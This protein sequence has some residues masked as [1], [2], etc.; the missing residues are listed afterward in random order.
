MAR[1]RR[2][3]GK[4][5]KTVKL[6]SAL[7]RTQVGPDETPSAL[8]QHLSAQQGADLNEIELAQDIALLAADIMDEL[9]DAVER[10]R[11]QDAAATVAALILASIPE[12]QMSARATE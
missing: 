2:T 7:L 1:L 8:L 9:A 12:I 6:V 11:V 3:F 4:S 5:V 10:G